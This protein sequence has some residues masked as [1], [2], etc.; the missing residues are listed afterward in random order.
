MLAWIPPDAPPDLFPPAWQALAHPNGLLAAGGD[1]SPARLIAAY[2]LGIFPW[3]SDGEPI[4]WWTPDP[5]NILLP[6]EMRV[7]RSLRKRIRRCDY[8]V[9]VDLAFAE[10]IRGCAAPRR[11]DHGTWIDTEMTHAYERLHADGIAHSVECWD[12]EDLVGGLYGLAL[13]GVFFGESMFSRKTD[14]SK[15]ALA[16]LCAQG[17]RLIDCQVPN[18]HLSSLGAR[19]VP[20]EQFEAHLARALDE[21]AVTLRAAC[22]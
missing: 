22:A 2:K 3:Y 10:V 4:L 8:A 19:S 7:S 6:A 11:A 16:H 17:F 1:L 20:R 21:P 12:G 9:T 18:P 5:R 14:A 13:G 15:V